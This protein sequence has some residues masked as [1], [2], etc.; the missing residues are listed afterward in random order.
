MKYKKPT[1]EVSPLAE[2][3]IICTS[4]LVTDPF[5]PYPGEGEDGENW[6]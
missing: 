5:K 6:D 3:N 2:E 4:T 1:M